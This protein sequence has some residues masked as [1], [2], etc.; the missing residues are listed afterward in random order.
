MDVTYRHT[1]QLAELA[2]AIAGL[3]DLRSDAELPADVETEGVAPVL[4]T[5]VSRDGEVTWFADRILEIERSV[6]RLPS[7]AILVNGEDEV[8]WVAEALGTALAANNVQV[9]A[10]PD[11]KVVGQ[12]SA[13]RVF[14][15][16]HIKGLEFEAVFF[17]RVDR[18]AA[19]E[20]D[21]FD[22]FL[23][24][25]ATRAATY[26]GIT[27]GTAAL[28]ARMAAISGLFGVDWAAL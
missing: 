4:A 7:I 27:C 17:S 10:C 9:S 21:L 19:Q 12:E 16:Q 13:V 24:V 3:G 5:A 15:V 1:R 28:P 6:R 23:Y 26:L 25:G 8:D 2:R 14:H 20:P 18:L 11:G 22:K